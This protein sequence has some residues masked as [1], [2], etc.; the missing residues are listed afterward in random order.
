[1]DTTP[2][3]PLPAPQA[4]PNVHPPWSAWSESEKLHVACAYSNPFRW[5]TRR[6]LM[7]DFRGH[8]NACPNVLLHT[9]ELAYGDRPFE[10]TGSD[11]LDVQLRTG[12]ELWHKE[13]I[14]NTVISR[15]PPGWKYGAYV[16]ADFAMTRQDWA[17]EAIHQLQHH[18]FV[19]L[20]SS[21]AD[22]TADH[23]PFR[24]QP[25]FAYAQINYGKDGVPLTSL[26]GYDPSEA[27]RPSRSRNTT[28]GATGGAWAFR[29]DA[30]DSVGSLLDT[31]ILGAADWYM[32]FGFIGRTTDGH[33]EATGCGA[34]Y[35]TSVRRWQERA[36]Q[37]LKGNIGYIDNHA[38]H[39]WHGSKNHRAYGTRWQ[40]L[41][42]NHFDP[43][44]DIYRDWQGVWQLTENKPK[45][46]DDI[47]RYFLSRSEDNPTFSPG[48]T[49]LV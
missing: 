47:R 45:L 20:F 33:P 26:T 32:A 31:C 29:R 23:R 6:H 30:L 11:G 4:H 9:G 3:T 36:F 35:E 24:I 38:V 21:Y 1:M 12:H 13:N 44:T 34:P 7:N 17:L 43:N 41:R 15:F 14:L 25:S 49:S 16:D 48:E 22:L 18:G 8:M 37:A 42:D 5:R 40:I 10:V 2:G 19:Q 39:H 27:P 46:R 28:P